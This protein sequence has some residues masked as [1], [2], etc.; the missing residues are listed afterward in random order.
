MI[1]FLGE[2]T[3]QKQP[4][5]MVKIGFTAG[6]SPLQRKGSCQT[7]NPRPLRLLCELYGTPEDERRL[8]RALAPW[9]LNGEWFSL[10][11]RAVRSLKEFKCWRERPAEGVID[12]LAETLADH[13]RSHLK[14]IAG[15]EPTAPRRPVPDEDTERAREALRAYKWRRLETS[16]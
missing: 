13:Q 15:E 11:E 14:H 1:Y 16:S 4:N 2:L 8:H 9:R 6:E 12:L 7:G 5:G 3:A 10:S